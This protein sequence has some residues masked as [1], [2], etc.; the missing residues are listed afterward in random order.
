MK[1]VQLVVTGKCE[2]SLHV[3]LRQLFP[4]LDWP[5]PIFANSFTS[6][7]LAEPIP[8]GLRTTLDKF[9]ETLARNVDQD[10]E[11]FVIGVDDVEANEPEEIVAALRGAVERTLQQQASSAAR[12][13]RLAQRLTERCSFHLLRPMVE[14]Y[15][16]AAP[17]A[18]TRAGVVRPSR[19]DTT[20][21]VERFEVVDEEAPI[22]AR[23]HPKRYLRF[24]TN[25]AYRETRG[26]RAALESLEWDQVLARELHVAAVRSLI[27]DI[28]DFAAVGIRPGKELADTSRSTSRRARVL[29]NL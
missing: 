15:F 21:D 17:P 25:D 6:T 20:A 4:E 7:T 18:L 11:T 9:A 26:G 29:R 22:E 13:G 3:S 16:F 19:F 14:A 28:A 8:R 24:L 27:N 10:D 1:R 23:R 12:R 5:E 2:Q